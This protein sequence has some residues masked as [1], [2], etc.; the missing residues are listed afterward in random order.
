MPIQCKYLPTW[1][2]VTRFS[3]WFSSEALTNPGKVWG[4]GDLERDLQRPLPPLPLSDC[5]SNRLWCWL[6]CCK[7]G[8]P[9]D[10]AASES[11]VSR[12]MSTFLNCK[13]CAAGGSGGICSFRGVKT[14]EISVWVRQSQDLDMAMTPKSA[15]MPTEAPTEVAAAGAVTSE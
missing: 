4:R 8:R 15:A 13:N 3:A 12:D 1:G 7:P 10:V 2:E 6:N 14:A 9:E 5:C 11:L